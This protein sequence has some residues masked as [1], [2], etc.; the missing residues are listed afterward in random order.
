MCTL[1]L[2]P[3]SP[4]L[5]IIQTVNVSLFGPSYRANQ[6]VSSKTEARCGFGEDL[7]RTPFQTSTIAET[8]PRL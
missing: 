8:I 7:L 3:L 5:L 1:S 2:L 6:S 4:Y